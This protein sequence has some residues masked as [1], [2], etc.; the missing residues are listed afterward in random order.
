[1]EETYYAMNP[2]WEGRRA[3]TGI[4]RPGYL[5]R[6]RAALSRKQVELVIGGRRVGKTTLVRQLVVQCLDDGVPPRD[7]LY[8]GLDHPQLSATRIS[9]HLRFFRSLFGHERARKLWLIFDEVQESPDWEREI[10]A[11]YDLEN[12]KLICTGSTAALVASQG[13]KLTGRQALLTVYPLSLQEFLTFRGYDFS[14]AEDYRFVAAAE[15]YLQTGGYPEQVLLSASFGSAQDQSLKAG[16]PSDLY[17]A[18]LLQDIVARDLVRR[19]R[20]RLPE[21][22]QDLLRLLAAGAGTRTSTN[23]LAKALGVSVDTVK[24]YISYLG[25]AYLVRTLEKWTSSH[26]ER[27]YAQRKVYLLDTGFKTLLTGSGDLGAKAETAVFVDFVR[28]AEAAK[29]HKSLGYY[30]ESDREVD[31]VFGPRGAPVAVEVKYEDL[32]TWEDRRFDGVRL[33]L[34]RF[35]ACREVTV[36]TRDASGEVEVGP[37]KVTAVPLWRYLLR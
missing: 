2:W 28:R 32:F 6:L 4:P 14:R 25:E 13:G 21:L 24:D 27:I 29:G 36:V 12:V 8:L 34:R 10:K 20:I 16:Q 22:A 35:P 19:E 5:S 9:E 15:E 30:A 11:I 23:R 1:M 3:D 17:L 31:F 37:A 18:Q 7:V 33:F 26:T